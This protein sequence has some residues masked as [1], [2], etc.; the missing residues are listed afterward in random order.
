MDDSNQMQPPLTVGVPREQLP[1]ERR[2]ALV[3]DVVEDLTR[4]GM[5]V[6]VEPG[7]GE[8][9]YHDDETYF[10]AGARI[11]SRPGAVHR[12]ADIL[13]KVQPPTPQEIEILRPGTLSISFLDAER[14]AALTPLLEQREVIAFSFNAVPRVTRAQS[15][16]AMSAMSTIAGYKAV[17]L[18][19]NASPRLFPMLMTAA[20]TVTPA[21]VVVIGAGVAGLQALATARRLGAITAACDARPEVREQ[22]QSVGATFI[23]MSVPLDATGDAGGYARQM[24]EE[25]YRLERA[26]I[27]EYIE[28]ADVVISTAQIPGVKAPILIDEL[29]VREMRPGSVIVDLAAEAGGNCELTVP[30]ETLVAHGVS[31]LGPFNVPSM[32]PVHASQMYSRNALSVIKHVV[33]D[34]ALRMDPE[35]QILRA[36]CLTGLTAAGAR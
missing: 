3:P 10:L 30:G 2:V 28:G 16:D 31:I 17:L 34:G 6:V 14:A 29:M 5:T 27:R 23:D 15:M 8:G 7:A 20:G 33:K 4:L 9:A 25:F 13:V 22:I 1:G 21:R 36:A 26:A 18:A 35:D 12:Q 11:E 19:A 32:V 24:D